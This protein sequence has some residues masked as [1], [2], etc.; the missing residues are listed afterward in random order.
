MGCFL[1]AVHTVREQAGFSHDAMLILTCRLCYLRCGAGSR[2]LLCAE[3]TEAVY[4]CVCLCV[5]DMSISAR[6]GFHVCSDHAPSVARFEMLFAEKALGSAWSAQML[7]SRS[8]V[9]LAKLLLTR[10]CKPALSAWF[11]F[12][13]LA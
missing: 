10:A 4:V 3:K 8:H 12:D 9:C 6:L 7:Q 11:M 1:P 2:L 13:W 5:H